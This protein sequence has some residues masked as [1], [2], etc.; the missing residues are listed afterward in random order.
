MLKY[1]RSSKIIFEQYCFYY[2]FLNRYWEYWHKILLKHWGVYIFHTD[3]ILTRYISQI[4]ANICNIVRYFLLVTFHYK[5]LQCKANI[6]CNTS[7]FSGIS[8]QLFP[9]QSKYLSNIG[10]SLEVFPM[11]EKLSQYRAPI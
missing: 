11:N 5:N 1:R 6:F 3:S 8:F 10:I 2:L 4:L 9:K 7:V